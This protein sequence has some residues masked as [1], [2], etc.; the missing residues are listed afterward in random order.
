MVV[1]G[2]RSAMPGVRLAPLDL[3]GSLAALSGCCWGV[4]RVALG[5]ARGAVRHPQRSFAES[6]P[7]EE[8]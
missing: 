4:G 6:R 2:L 1:E 7:S 8:A 3:A 5:P